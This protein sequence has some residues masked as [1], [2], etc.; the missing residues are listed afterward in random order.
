LRSLFFPAELDGDSIDINLNFDLESKR[1]YKRFAEN[2]ILIAERLRIGDNADKNLI[3]LNFL[4]DKCLRAA[5]ISIILKSDIS[6][7]N[8]NDFAIFDDLKREQK[9]YRGFNEKIPLSL[10][11]LE[12]KNAANTNN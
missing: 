1:F 2:T 8:L 6:A 5:D 7:V 10:F 9:L 11:N 12:Q 3:F 4:L